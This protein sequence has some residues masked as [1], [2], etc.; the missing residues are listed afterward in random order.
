[1]MSLM[2]NEFKLENNFNADEIIAKSRSLKGV[3]EPFLL[4]PTEI[5]V[6]EHSEIL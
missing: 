1:M 6:K 2:Y 4:M 3:M 5:Y